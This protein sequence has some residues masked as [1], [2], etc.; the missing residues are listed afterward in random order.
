MKL[1]VDEP[2]KRPVGVHTKSHREQLVDG[3]CAFEEFEVECRTYCTLVDEL[4][5]KQLDLFVLDVEG[6]EIEVLEG[7]RG[8]QLW[9]RVFVIEF[10]HIGLDRI[11]RALHELNPMYTLDFCKFNNAYFSLKDKPALRE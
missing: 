4:K 7:M 2:Q 3:G 6:H 11:K 8:T 10:P 1:A 9:P 5:L